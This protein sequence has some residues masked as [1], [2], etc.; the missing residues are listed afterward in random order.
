MKALRNPLLRL[1]LSVA[2]A[3]A[4]AAHADSVERGS[5]ASLGASLLVGVSAAW[6]AH[7]GSTFT[8]QAVQASGDVVALSLEGASAASRTSAEIARTAAE[9][10]SVGVGSVV[11]VVAESTG[12]A[13][14][15]SGKVLAFVPNEIGRAML[16]HARHG[17]GSAK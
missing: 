10:A 2:A 8:V 16:F 14:V 1:A 9:A 7:E 15:A 11:R 5:T 17:G 3:F 4:P 12:T 13:L 6:V